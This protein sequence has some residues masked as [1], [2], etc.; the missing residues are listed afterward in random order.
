MVCHVGHAHSSVIQDHQAGGKT[1]KKEEGKVRSR[2]NMRGKEANTH[3]HTATLTLIV[4]ICM[5]VIY[6]CF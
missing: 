1:Q 4:L 3:T 6:S 5:S 2:N